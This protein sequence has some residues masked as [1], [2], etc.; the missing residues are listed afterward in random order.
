[1]SQTHTCVHMCMSLCIYTNYQRTENS[2][3]LHL[4]IPFYLNETQIRLNAD[5]LVAQAV[6]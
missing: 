3:P 1:M 6:E 5:L 2:V 4:P